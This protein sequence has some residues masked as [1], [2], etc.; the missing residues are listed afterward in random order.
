MK[1]TA[2]G[3]NH[4]YSKVYQRGRR[5]VGRYT[6]VYVLADRRANALMRANPM[7]VRINRIGITCT[8][9]IGKAV[10]R[11]RVKRIIREAWRQTDLELCVK[12]GN[13]VV[14]AARDGIQN[15]KTQDVKAEIGRAV[16]KLGLA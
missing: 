2:I 4:L 14:I 16:K 10:I 3:E 8:K 13:L 11:S 7:K 12:K 5:F 9:K 6:A 15:V 1:P